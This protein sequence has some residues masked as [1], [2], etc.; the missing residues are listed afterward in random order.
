MEPVVNKYPNFASPVPPASTDPGRCG[1][2]ARNAAATRAPPKSFD[3]SFHRPWDDPTSLH[4]PPA[5]HNSRATLI[6]ITLATPLHFIRLGIST[7]HRARLVSPSAAPSFKAQYG[8]SKLFHESISP[9]GSETAVGAYCATLSQ[10]RPRSL[11]H[12]PRLACTTNMDPSDIALPEILD[13]I[14]SYLASV[15]P[16]PVYSI[17]LT[18][19]SHAL[20]LITTL[21]SLSATLI[22]SRPW[23]WEATTVIPLVISILTAY[24]A[25]LSAW[26][27]VSWMVRTSLWFA[28]W[29]TIFAALAAGLGWMAG[30]GAGAGVG[31]AGGG[32]M[33]GGAMSYLGGLILDAIN[34]PGQN[35]AGAPRTRARTQSGT[36]PKAW[37]SFQQHR[38]WQY[39][40]GA[41]NGGG[42]EL[43][44][45]LQGVI[46]N[47]MGGG[48]MDAA[49]NAWNDLQTAAVPE[50]EGNTGRRKQPS[51][52]AKTKA[53]GR[54]R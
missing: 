4:T 25:L 53:Q 7:T 14:L 15:L 21:A 52:Q 47:I 24:L 42:G 11:G 49:K 9:P 8:M 43:N 44:E 6:I 17:L 10:L 5:I 18:V 13:P 28:K 51:R 29:G 34:G 19:C 20:A 54:S 32:A 16:P 23:E 48:W 27:T 50:A 22:Q 40:E 26:R 45:V 12:E 39:Q 46:G 33:A 37:E 30:G 3:T 35:A 41:N 38:D 2:S 36:R 1:L 31:Q